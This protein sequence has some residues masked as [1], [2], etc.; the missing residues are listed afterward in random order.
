[1]WTSW[2]V[3]GLNYLSIQAYNVKSTKLLRKMEEYALILNLSKEY[4]WHSS[5]F[6]I[7]EYSKSCALTCSNDSS[8]DCSTAVLANTTIILF[9]P[10][11]L[12]TV[13]F[14]NRDRLLL[15]H[16]NKYKIKSVKKILSVPSICVVKH[17]RSIPREYQQK[18]NNLKSAQ[19]YR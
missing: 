10:N 7:C 17:K 14:Y 3:D 11:F 8:H 9:P 1:M 15:L 12:Y 19:P 5:L 18:K 6:H 13:V 16:I 4:I 2:S